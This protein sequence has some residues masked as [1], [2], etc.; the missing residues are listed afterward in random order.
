M[1][2]TFNGNEWL[3]RIENGEPSKVLELS[4]EA[5]KWLAVREEELLKIDP[6]TAEAC[7]DY[8]G[9]SDPYNFYP[10]M[11]KWARD[12]RDRRGLL[13]FV[14]RSDGEVWVW[15]GYLPKNTRN[16]LSR[17][18]KRMQCGVP[19]IRDVT[20]AT[21][22][23][24]YYRRCSTMCG[25][26]IVNDDRPRR[27]AELPPKGG[28]ELRAI[29]RQEALKIDPETADVCRSRG[30]GKI[31]DLPGEVYD[32]LFYRRRGSNVWVAETYLADALRSTLRERIASRRINVLWMR[33]CD[34]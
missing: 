25:G 34:V 11:P 12:R 1:K 19:F 2:M 16:R 21:R 28:E 8:G 27:P 31:D 22:P 6:D 4:E 18:F 15:K 3:A 24:R 23:I 13:D 30:L 20:A 14:R 5:Q 7:F 10:K 17:R 9:N 29:V 32:L 26:Q 33:Q